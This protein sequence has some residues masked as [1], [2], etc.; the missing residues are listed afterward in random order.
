M[1]GDRLQDIK[2]ALVEAKRQ[3]QNTSP[4]TTMFPESTVRWLV[5]E[6]ESQRAEVLAAIDRV[7]PLHFEQTPGTCACERCRH[8]RELLTEL[9]DL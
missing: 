1:S 9:R 2:E 4:I 8:R 6:I 3:R 5:S 7:F